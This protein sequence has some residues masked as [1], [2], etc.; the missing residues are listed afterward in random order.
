MSLSRYIP[1]K[2]ITDGCTRYGMQ[3]CVIFDD[4]L[5]GKKAQFVTHA[6]EMS[7]EIL[8]GTGQTAATRET[9]R[10]YDVIVAIGDAA[11]IN[12]FLVMRRVEDKVYET[13]YEAARSIFCG[14]ASFLLDLAAEVALFDAAC[15]KAHGV[16]AKEAADKCVYGCGCDWMSKAVAEADA[17]VAAMMSVGEIKLITRVTIGEKAKAMEHLLWSAYTIVDPETR[18][19]YE[20]K[21]TRTI[22]PDGKRVEKEAI[23]ALH[24]DMGRWPSASLQTHRRRPVAE[25]DFDA[26]MARLAFD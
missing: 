5:P 18:V 6:L 26:A 9:L 22:A 10:R 12:D 8:A 23:A 4:D 24:L 11:S 16:D 25:F 14:N 2:Y 7:A 15:R 21:Y 17:Y 1:S 3:P 20:R 13:H 19:N